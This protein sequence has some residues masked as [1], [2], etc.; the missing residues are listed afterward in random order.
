[1]FWFDKVVSR[2]VNVIE[3]YIKSWIMCW[4]TA[5]QLFNGALC[6]GFG[7]GFG[8]C[9][10]QLNVWKNV[11][12]IIYSLAVLIV[13]KVWFEHF[14][15]VK[16]LRV[17]GCLMLSFVDAEWNR[18]KFWMKKRSKTPRRLSQWLKCKDLYFLVLYI[19]ELINNFAIAWIGLMWLVWARL[20]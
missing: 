13:L 4:K 17:R 16:L 19:I 11:I 1:M 7:F 5:Y 2:R 8:M 10:F 18:V 14:G 6:L 9:R 12:L 20:M 3:V 15:S